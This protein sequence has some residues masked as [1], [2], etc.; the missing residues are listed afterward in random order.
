[1]SAV[2]RLRLLGVPIMLV[3]ASMLVAAP[4]AAADRARQLLA[5]AL[6]DDPLAARQWNLQAAGVNALPLM[7]PPATIFD[8]VT[9]GL[10]DGG[11][12]ATNPDLA[13]TPQL[14]GIVVTQKS[15]VPGQPVAA[16]VHG[17]LVAGIIGART[18]ND[19]GIASIAPSVRI[20]DLQV[21]DQFGQIQ[22]ATE[23]AAIRYAVTYGARV[24]NL[25]LGAPRDPGRSDD[26]YSAAEAEAVRFA[27]SR[28]VLVVAA[29]GNTAGAQYA[30]WPAALP[31]VLSVGSVNEQRQVS[32]FS[33]HDPTRL[34]LVAPGEQVISLV[35][36]SVARSGLSIDAVDAGNGLVGGD[37]TVAGT[38][39]AAPH[40]TAAAALLWSLNPALTAAQVA[41]ILES[42]TRVVGHTPHDAASGFGELNVAQAASRALATP[43]VVPQA[44]EPN[45]DTGQQAPLVVFA[46][47]RL[48]TGSVSY[49]DDPLDVFR[50]VLGA[51]QRFDARLWSSATGLVDLAVFPPQTASIA[52]SGALRTERSFAL[53]AVSTGRAKRLSVRARRAG[54]YYVVVWARSGVATYLLALRRSR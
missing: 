41:A 15:F 24:I 47:T 31:H 36:I 3:V 6:P 29:A 11:V 23:A 40:V 39:F 28:G 52:G 51:G 18:G 19:F 45:D 53:A 17:T 26:G 13:A 42:T 25:S 35:P 4:A 22:P 16:S 54:S 7:L 32:S 9:V 34:D 43:P 49:Y 48:V 10:V 2:R 37:G 38:S 20:L 27:V 30:D 14:P 1:M 5:A 21:V 12:D 44:M 33:N 46:R 8:P 50:V